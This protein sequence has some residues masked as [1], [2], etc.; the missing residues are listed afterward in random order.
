MKNKIDLSIVIPVYNSS[1]NLLKLVKEI[2]IDL[3]L[4][5]INKEIILIN[6]FSNFKT[7][8]LLKKIIQKYKKIKL[9]NLKK[10]SGQHY[11][12]LVGIDRSAGKYI[13]TLDDDLEHSPKS[14]YKMLLLLKKYNY[15]VVFERNDL[16]KN[17]WRNFTSKLNQWLIRKVFGL[18]KNVITSSFRI[19]KRKFAKKI[20][21][22]NFNNPN[23]SCMILNQ[24]HNIGNLKVKYKTSK[25][26]TRYTIKKLI[27]LNGVIL[28]GYSNLVIK[29]TTIISF[30]ACFMSAVYG[31]TSLIDNLN[32]EKSFLGWISTIVLLSFFSAIIIFSQYLIITYL[33]ELSD[34]KKIDKNN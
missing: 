25:T 32:N 28:F 19:I 24:T 16:N 21:N 31:I 5:K 12:T 27:N 18:K 4:K 13:V 1:N 8:I 20:L 15:D 22:E 29:I 26:K 33:L 17:L 10:N 2:Y 6:D 23:I 14:I 3:N 30:I 11:S 7:K 9:I 34:K